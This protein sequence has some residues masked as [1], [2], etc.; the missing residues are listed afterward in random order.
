MALY[1]HFRSKEELLGGL[2]ERVWAEIGTDVDEADWL[3][4]P[5][6]PG[7][8]GGN[9]C[10][11]CRFFPQSQ[12]RARISAGA[13]SSGEENRLT[14]GRHPAARQQRSNRLSRGGHHAPDVREAV[15]GS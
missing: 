5:G 13:A 9:R 2:I 10:D 15:P 7:S 1:W 11:E 14:L 6:Q 8:G 3:A 12:H 4:G